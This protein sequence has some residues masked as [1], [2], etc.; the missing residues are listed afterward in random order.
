MEYCLIS[1]EGQWLSRSIHLH[2]SCQE[3]NS[4]SWCPR[5]MMKRAAKRKRRL[6][7]RRLQERRMKPLQ[8][9]LNG[10]LLQDNQNWWLLI[11][12]G[13]LSKIWWRT[14]SLIIL[15]VNKEMLLWL[16]ALLKRF[17]SLLM[18]QR[19]SQLWL[20]L[21]LFIKILDTLSKQS[22]ALRKQGRVGESLYQHKN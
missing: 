7:K 6:L 4:E 20:S 17:I 5:R 1:Q 10:H 2:T 18:L 3:L 12:S 21:Q 16:L 15:E 9:Q 22:T 8:S 19:T 14:F 11:L 13:R